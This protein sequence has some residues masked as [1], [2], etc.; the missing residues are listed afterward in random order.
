MSEYDLRELVLSGKAPR[1][2]RILMAQ[3]AIP[4][5]TKEALELLIHLGKENDEEISHQ[6]IKTINDWDKPEILALLSHKDCSDVILDFFVDSGQ[7]EH[8]LQA[9]ATNPSASGE[10]IAR[11]ASAASLEL[12]GL[13]LDNRTRILEFPAILDSIRGNPSADARIIGLIQEIET[14]FLGEKRKDYSIES[15][16]ETETETD[17]IIAAPK[18]ALDF[19]AEIAE[20]L[21]SPLPD[22]DFSIESLHLDGGDDEINIAVR[23]ASMPPKEK[24][25]YA[26]FGTREL[27]SILIRDSNREV[28]RTVL[29]SPKLTENEIEGISAMRSVSDDILREIGNSREWLKNTIVVN[30]L[31]KNPKTPPMIAQRLMPRL[32]TREIMLMSRDRS[33]PDATRNNAQRLLKQRISNGT[34]A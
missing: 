33:L 24:I 20:L 32:R 12:L 11:L 9:I 21:S 3:G 14:E 23:I 4:L 29:R 15:T 26:L 22:I 28:A 5:P 17:D 6:A 27:R 8:I 34:N 7:P 2:V 30:N 25:K 16:L 13:I 18:V 10:I 31:V 19:E 1:N